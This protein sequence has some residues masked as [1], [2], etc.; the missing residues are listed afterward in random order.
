MKKII[1]ISLIISMINL[2]GCYYQEHMTPSSYNF[3]DHSDIQIITSDTTYK[4]NG[5][6][7][8]LANDTLFTTIPKQIDERTTHKL[9]VN[10]PVSEIKSVQVERTDAFASIATALGVITVILALAIAIAIALSESGWL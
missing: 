5:K 3:D 7:Y 1:V 9:K 2:M 6:D 8:H 4:L 10:I